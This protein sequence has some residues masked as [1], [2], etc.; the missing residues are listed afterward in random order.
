MEQVNAFNY[1][2]IEI[3]CQ[4][5]MVCKKPQNTLLVDL[6]LQLMI[7][8]QI[9]FPPQLSESIWPRMCLKLNELFKKKIKKI[10]YYILL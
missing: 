2:R 5:H 8:I 9:T 1:L 6:K 10:L 3:G 7:A 4:S